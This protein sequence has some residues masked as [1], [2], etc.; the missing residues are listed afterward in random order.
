MTRI[1]VT[2]ASGLLGL[3][4][5]LTYSRQHQVTGVVNAHALAGAPFQVLNADLA[6]PGSIGEILDRAKPD[7]VLHCAALANVDQC[8]RQ[9]ELAWRLNADLPE[10]VAQA[11]ARRGIALVHVS[12]DAVFDGKTGGYTE[13]SQPNPLSAYARTK[14]A[15]EHAVLQAYPDALVARVN[16]YG[17]SLSG[18]RSLAEFFFN[19]LSTGTPVRGF[20][21]VFFCPL[22]VTILAEILMR[23]VD[24]HCNGIYHVVSGECLSKYEFGCAVARRFELDEGLIQPVSVDEGDLLAAR[25]PDLRLRTDKLASALGS[26]APDQKTSLQRFFELYRA[27]YPQRLRA[28][29]PGVDSRISG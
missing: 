4:F 18:Q 23:L 19:H 21:D 7:V 12:T 28:L 9:P 13:E 10:E 20:T 6:R 17:W 24:A 15:A 5:A 2:G 1:L 8:E 3:N 16:F 11:T 26:P 27:G 14:L 22:E 29:A 25:S